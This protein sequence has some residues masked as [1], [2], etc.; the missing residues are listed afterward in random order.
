MKEFNINDKTEREVICIRN[1]DNKFIG[2]DGSILL[3]EIGQTYTVKSLNVSGS[4]TEV[5]VKEYPYI[6]FDSGCFAEK[7][8]D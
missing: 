6:F 5:E 4:H 3:L 7:G 1:E 8:G 2:V